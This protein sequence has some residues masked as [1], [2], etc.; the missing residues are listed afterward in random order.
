MLE[1]VSK[2]IEKLLIFKFVM[3]CWKIASFQRSHF[4][5]KEL[6]FFPQVSSSY[7]AE[8]ESAFQKEKQ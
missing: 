4:T 5:D 8:H 1:E 6:S 3:A 2:R 7:L